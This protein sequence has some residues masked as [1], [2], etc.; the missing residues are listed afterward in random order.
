MQE[1]SAKLKNN[2]D[3]CLLWIGKK[4]LYLRKMDLPCRH[5]TVW[6]GVP[7]HKAF[8]ELT[9]FALTCIVTR[10]NNAVVERIFSL[11]S[12]VKTKARN[13]MQLNRLG[14]NC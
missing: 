7:Q 8:K 13:G 6:I 3:K 11:V 10:I 9:T 1:T 12:S 4:K 2:T 5:R 14:Q